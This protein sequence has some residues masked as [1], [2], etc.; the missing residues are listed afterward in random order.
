MMCTRFMQRLLSRTG[1]KVALPAVVAV[2]LAI[3]VYY[4]STDGAHST[5]ACVNTPGC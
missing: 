2:A 4:T 3:F 5:N 1:A